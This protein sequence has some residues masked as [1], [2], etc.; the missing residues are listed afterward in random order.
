MLR[1]V[2]AKATLEELAALTP[3]TVV[4]G[5]ILVRPEHPIAEEW[6][7][8]GSDDA[9]R[10]QLKL[11]SCAGF[12]DAELKAELRAALARFEGREQLCLGLLFNAPLAEA[13]VPALFRA[14]ELRCGDAMAEN[15]PGQLAV[16]RARAYFYSAH[17][18]SI[19]RTTAGAACEFS[20]TVDRASGGA[21]GW[22]NTF[23]PTHN[24]NRAGRYA[25]TQRFADEAVASV[26]WRD[27][28]VGACVACYFTLVESR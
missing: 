3:E 21:G 19:F 20:C 14:L 17:R 18:I 22:F 12:F 2:Y 23:A 13:D 26:P 24:R 4:P 10:Y 15:V 25:C 1:E 11:N 9:D 28:G 7:L 16:E 27:S 5:F 8:F 6:S